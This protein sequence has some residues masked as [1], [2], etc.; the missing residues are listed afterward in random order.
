MIKGVANK[1]VVPPAQITE[2]RDCGDPH[3]A[4]AAVRADERFERFSRF[5]RIGLP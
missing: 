4:L 2:R 5:E 3:K 1:L